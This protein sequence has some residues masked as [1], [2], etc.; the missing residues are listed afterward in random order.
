MNLALAY[1]HIIATEEKMAAKTRRGRQ[2]TTIRK[3]EPSG[4]VMTPAEEDEN[5]AAVVAMLNDDSG[6]EED[7]QG[8]SYGHDDVVTLRRLVR[9]WQ[10][11]VST[12]D[13]SVP[14]IWKLALSSEDRSRLERFIKSLQVY[15]RSDL[16]M[17]V[18]DGSP[19]PY[20]PA[21]IQFT[22][23][24]RNSQN[25]RLCR[26][27]PG[28]TNDE[29]CGRWFLRQD[30]HER[31]FCQRKCAA[32]AAKA[33]ER[34]RN[35][36]ATLKKA[37]NAITDYENLRRNHAAKLGVESVL[38]KH[39]KSL[40]LAKRAEMEREIKRTRKCWLEVIDSEDWKGAASQ[41][42][43]ISK[44]FLTLAVTRGELTAPRRIVSQITN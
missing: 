35:H 20:D 31:K 28:V 19:T 44:K 41:V 26:P 27:C 30:R 14:F 3:L 37:A 18:H 17:R 42:T 2:F 43:G 15:F 1:D 6:S 12:S 22:R 8:K 39:K 21:A 24:I 4:F 36:K 32:N 29:V 34:A 11:A 25:W 10:D 13:D 9:A 38:D 16:T 7:W 23:L 5:L 40:T 33:E